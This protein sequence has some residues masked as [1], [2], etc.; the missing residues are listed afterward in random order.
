MLYSY[1]CVDGYV[2]TRC[3]RHIER[4]GPYAI[5]PYQGAVWMRRRVKEPWRCCRC[6]AEMLDGSYEGDD[7]T[8]DN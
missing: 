1:Y 7:E 2:R 8:E 3:R 4:D 5:V 6:Y